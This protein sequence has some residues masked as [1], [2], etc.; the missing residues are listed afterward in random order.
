MDGDVIGLA[1]VV[2]TLGIPLGAMYTYYCVRKLR[3]DERLAALARGAEIPMQPELSSHATSR[4]SG[5]LL[6]AGSLG[7]MLTFAL[8]GRVEHDA[9]IAGLF[10]REKST[11]TPA[12]I[13]VRWAKVVPRS[14]RCQGPLP[15]CSVQSDV[16]SP[17]SL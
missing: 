7:Y 17:L 14:L 15:A 9:W 1:A 8:I 10:V 4:R 16:S 6:V 12:T 11:R 5:I 3:T 13:G 2:M